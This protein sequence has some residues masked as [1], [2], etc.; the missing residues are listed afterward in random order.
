MMFGKR[1]LFY[2]EIWK[3]KGVRKRWV[4]LYRSNKMFRIYNL[5]KVCFGIC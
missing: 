3:G 2:I 1:N 5:I 4:F